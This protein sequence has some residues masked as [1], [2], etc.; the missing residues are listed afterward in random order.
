[1]ARIRDVDLLQACCGSAQLH[2]LL[3]SLP[4]HRKQ[5][6]QAERLDLHGDVIPAR[7]VVCL[8]GADWNV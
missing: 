3:G 5:V 2:W 1:M 4:D 8:N 7:A 6:G